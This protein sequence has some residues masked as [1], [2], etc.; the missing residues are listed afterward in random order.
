M[1]ETL[2]NDVEI[3][4]LV[5][6]YGLDEEWLDKSKCLELSLSDNKNIIKI[7]DKYNDIY[8]VRI[9]DKFYLRIDNQELNY[10]CCKYFK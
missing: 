9:N 3:L 5:N 10:L 6:E 7:I 1:K 8:F 2:M 4:K